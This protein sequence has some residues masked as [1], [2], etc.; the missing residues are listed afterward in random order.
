MNVSPKFIIFLQLSQLFLLSI[1][2]IGAN[3]QGKMSGPAFALAFLM[4]LTISGGAYTLIKYGINGR[5]KFFVFS[6]ANLLVLAMLVAH[7]L[8]AGVF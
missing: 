7:L 2:M 8:K 6:T 4:I 5:Q 1:L 3:S